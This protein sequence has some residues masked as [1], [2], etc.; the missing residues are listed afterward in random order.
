MSV[1]NLD[2]MF[3]PGSV[4]LI[5]ASADPRSVG[6]VLA[7]N[8]LAGDFA[9]P[10]WLVNPR[11]T[12]LHGHPVHPG[13]DALPAAPELAV[14]ATPPATVPGLI[15]GLARRGTRAVVVITAVAG[16]VYEDRRRLEQA[17]L[18][19]A[20]PGLV[21][22]LGPNSIGLMVP[23]IGLDASFAH[24]PPRPGDLALVAQS[25]ALVTAMLDWAEHRAFGFSHVVSLGD[26]IDVDFG[27]LL[28]YLAADTATRAILLYIESITHARKFMS[29]AR[30][31]ARTRPVIV[32][33]AG[34]FAEGARAAASHTGALAGA[35]EV[36]DA[37]FRRA[38]ML[39]VTTIEEL[40]DAAETLGTGVAPAGD[41]LAILT[42]G[43]G[44]GVLATDALIEQG[45]RLAELAPAT[46]AALDAVLPPTWSRGNPVDIIGDADGAR[47]AAA[48]DILLAD[49][50][51][52]ALLVLNVP[53]AVADSMAA[54]EAVLGRLAGRALPV[55][56]SWLGGARAAAA[57]RRF[58]AA[59]VPT[60]DTPEDAVRGFLHRVAH[61][62]AQAQ[63]METPPSLPEHVAPDVAAAQAV[64]AA[65]RADGR[66]MLT[67]PEAKAVLA[68]YGIPT[69]PTRVAATP[70]DAAAA[71]AALG[72]GPYAVKILSR[73]ISHKSDLGGVVLDLADPPAVA[74]A[75]RRIADRMSELAPAARRD[76]FT[77]QPMVRRPGAIELILGVVED[78][79]FG[80]VILFGQGGVAVEVVRDKAVALPPLNLA[81]ARALMDRTRVMRLLRGY[82]DRPPADLDA[83]ALTLVELSRL[84]A[85]LPDIIELDINPL[86]ADAA[87]VI[88]LDARIRLR[89]GAAPE[90]R[91]AIRPY[92][93]ELERH[94]RVAGGALLLV[95]P[96]RPEDEPRLIET[97]RQVDPTDVRTRFLAPLADLPHEMAARLSQIDYDREMTLI[98]LGGAGPIRGLAGLARLA[99]DPDGLRAEFAVIVRPD[100]KGHGVGMALMRH[101]IEYARGR[102]IG[103]LI[104]DV[105]AEN[106]PM[107]ALARDLGFTA[108]P[109]VAGV[110]Q[111]TLPLAPAPPAP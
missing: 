16:Q 23:G 5:G 64:L 92:P 15:D 11:R 40:F 70:G 66:D 90:P 80:P 87:G 102:G 49:P 51:A 2:R 18:D 43:G 99:A 61:T 57:R 28:D 110:V 63:L 62:R 74:D 12:E 96:I 71:A 54:A 98:A 84:A 19:A 103:A 46:I 50:G 52:D 35:D 38:G 106:A 36:Y 94:V 44:I 29:A 100:V 14:I 6:G 59:R 39:R 73:D 32:I 83:I 81:L 60:Y 31:A 79:Q 47:Y 93:R 33:K 25:G 42:N 97:F 20:R 65:A 7:R 85:D 67:E 56:T 22:V 75:A 95:R 89:Q 88:A 78:R 82:R 27:D 72:A 30:S 105:R 1:R 101:L 4:A 58:A 76:G 34:R 68:A 3:R 37:A 45:G 10:R 109:A 48:L 104:G 24:I 17:M 9:G 111:V 13:I 26:M 41:R 21:R 69:V 55:L 91:L 108:A 86:L 8:L 107:L 53:T 77:V